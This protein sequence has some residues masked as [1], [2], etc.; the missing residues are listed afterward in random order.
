MRISAKLYT[1]FK[2]CLDN[3]HFVIDD[4][5]PAIIGPKGEQGLPGFPG[6][7]GDP[8]IPGLPGRDGIPGIEGRHGDVGLSGNNGK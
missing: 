4:S 5:G 1:P 3:I 2:L 7:N 6:A 8:G